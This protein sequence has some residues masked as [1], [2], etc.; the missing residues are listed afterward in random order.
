MVGLARLGL[1]PMTPPRGATEILRERAHLDFVVQVL[2]DRA[3]AVAKDEPPEE[4]ERRRVR[5][6]NLVVD[7]FD[8]WSKIAAEFSDTGTSLQYQKEIGSAQRL[9]YDMLD[10]ELKTLPQRRQKFRANR[11]LRD[12]EPS[13]N[14]WL[15]TLDGIEIEEDDE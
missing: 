11:S 8:D 12:V 3:A 13:V 10:P 5:V 7:L 2:S 9:L 6:K 1:A 4:I 15:K 14:L